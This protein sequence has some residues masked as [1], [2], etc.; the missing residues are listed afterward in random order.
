M[1]I[2]TS[3]LRLGATHES[4]RTTKTEGK[5]LAWIG[6]ERPRDPSPG[7]A[8]DLR[9]AVVGI[10]VEAR[11]KFLASQ[12]SALV[13]A[14][15]ALT[16]GIDDNVA[17]QAQGG[18][19]SVDGATSSAD[20]GEIG[21]SDL[22][23]TL[24]LLRDMVEALTGRRI[25]LLSAKDLQVDGADAART[26][27]V[28]RD[29][30][31]KR[32]E[33]APA[34]PP[35]QGWGVEVHAESTT[36]ETEQTKFSASG[37]VK[38]SDGREIAFET[39]L[40]MS[41]DRVTVETFDLRAGDAVVKDPLVLTFDGSAAELSAQKVAFDLNGD[42]K[43]E[44]ISTVKNGAFLAL[45][46]NGNGAIE[47][48]KEL[49]GPQSGSGFGELAQYDADKNGW[50]DE[51]DPVYGKL[52]LWNGSGAGVSLQQANVGAISLANAATPFDL[53]SADGAQLDGRVRATGVYLTEDGQA[54]V[55]Q[56][57]DLA[58]ASEHVNVTA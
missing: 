58:T 7:Q 21:D 36:V 38:T 17:G 20:P 24:R 5:L 16:S 50:I 29:L 18:A 54:K 27:R 11:A 42:G 8:V 23:P 47:S 14:M 30:G 51:N 10:S 31:T 40:S 9:G 55:I 48:G 41:R 12:T 3:E 37:V 34:P 45:D 43:N 39:T 4:A 13:S 46:K 26:E 33:P 22:T 32:G 19:T 53:R 35:K 2:D 25:R 1:R 49:F 52:R 44:A 15:K 6:D 57:V 56:Q 28:A